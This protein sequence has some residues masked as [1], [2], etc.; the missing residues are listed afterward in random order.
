MSWGFGAGGSPRER[1]DLVERSK[2]PKCPRMYHSLGSKQELESHLLIHY[3]GL[4]CD[5]YPLYCI[6]IIPDHS[7]HVTH[8]LHS[9][10]PIIIALDHVPKFPIASPKVQIKFGVLKMVSYFRLELPFSQL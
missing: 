7:K 6:I 3:L 1:L 5:I 8:S 9:S 4:L 2:V 10:L